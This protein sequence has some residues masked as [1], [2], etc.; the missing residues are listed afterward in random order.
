[1]TGRETNEL[2]GRSLGA[3]IQPQMEEVFRGKLADFFDCRP[4]SWLRYLS[5]MRSWQPPLRTSVG[6]AATQCD[7]TA[8]TRART[9]S[10]MSLLKANTT[11]PRGSSHRRPI[12][13]KRREKPGDC[14]RWPH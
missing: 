6:M 14:V 8:L 2:N 12:A 9:P 11:T 1:M 4:F 13:V 10:C 3:R 7:L 5:L